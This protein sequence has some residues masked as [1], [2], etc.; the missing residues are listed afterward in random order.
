MISD[1]RSYYSHSGYKRRSQFVLNP[2]DELGISSFW[3]GELDVDE[4]QE[5]IIRVSPVR[6][7]VMRLTAMF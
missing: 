1:G 2:P 6:I 7:K 4:G 5:G 3:P